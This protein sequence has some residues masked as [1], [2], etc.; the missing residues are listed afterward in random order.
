M[1]Q[2]LHPLVEM[3]EFLEFIAH[4]KGV[5]SLSRLKALLAKWRSRTPASLLD[6]ISVWDSVTATRSLLLTKLKE[7]LQSCIL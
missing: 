1:P 3:D 7:V 2:R 5:T 4:D 6:P